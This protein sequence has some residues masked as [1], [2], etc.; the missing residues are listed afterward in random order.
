MGH[1]WSWCTL[2]WSFG[3]RFHYDTRNV[4]HFS[5][6]I[7]HLTQSVGSFDDLT[8]PEAPFH[9]S[10]TLDVGQMS[11]DIADIV[12]WAIRWEGSPQLGQCTQSLLGFD[13][14]TLHLEMIR[15]SLERSCT[16]L[17]PWTMALFLLGR[18]VYWW[19]RHAIWWFD[20][21]GVNLPLGHPFWWW[22]GVL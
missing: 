21:S 15:H 12:I 9:T 17:S 11:S 3:G 18:W 22:V 20:D 14:R 13:L 16:L 8:C 10:W 4:M 2:T 19:W 1:V 6:D 5:E 7:A